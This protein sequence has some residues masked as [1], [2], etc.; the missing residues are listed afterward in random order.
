[1]NI[2]KLS[3]RGI[4]KKDGQTMMLK[5]VL[6]DLNRATQELDQLKKEM[7]GSVTHIMRKICCIEGL[8]LRVGDVK[9]IQEAVESVLIKEVIK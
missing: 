8:Y 2:Y 3:E 1:M 4:F 5:D 6:K 7:S 9:N